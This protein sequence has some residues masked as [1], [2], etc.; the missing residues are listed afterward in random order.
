MKRKNLCKLA[1]EGFVDT[2]KT[3]GMYN[4]YELGTIR[5]FY[6]KYKDKIVCRFDLN[7][8]MTKL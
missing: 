6:N 7:D 5:V 2:G 4:I 8:L 1:E 3:A